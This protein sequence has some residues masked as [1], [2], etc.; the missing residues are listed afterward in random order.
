[1]S[2]QIQVKHWINVLHKLVPIQASWSFIKGCRYIGLS[3][4]EEKLL[5]RYLNPI[6]LLNSYQPWLAKWQ[7]GNANRQSKINWILILTS[8]LI[9]RKDYRIW[10]RKEL[11]NIEFVSIHSARPILH[12]VFCTDGRLYFAFCLLR[13]QSCF[14]LHI[15]LFGHIRL[16]H[17]ILNWDQLLEADCIFPLHRLYFAFCILHIAGCILHRLSFLVTSGRITPIL[18]ET[19]HWRPFNE[20][21][22]TVDLQRNIVQVWQKI[23]MLD[24]NCNDDENSLIECCHRTGGGGIDQ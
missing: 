20:A 4:L 17:T 5:I 12:T 21:M 24:G 18:I 10:S 6:S 16:H 19:N 11:M 14:L 7:A 13:T 23:K 15:E 9:G 3:D 8:P 1:M 2:L 22:I